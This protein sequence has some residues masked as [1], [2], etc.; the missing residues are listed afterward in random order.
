MKKNFTLTAMITLFSLSNLQAETTEN[1]VTEFSNR[2]L[3]DWQSKSFSG[4][5]D[6]QLVKEQ[7]RTVLKATSVDSASG[8]ALEKRI[9][10]FQTPYINWSWRIENKLT[11]LD[12][13]TKQGDDY[14]ARIYLIIDGGWTVWK[15]QALN[16]VWSSNQTQQTQ[17][18]NAYVD[19][20][21]MLAVRG[22]NATP[23][24]WYTEKRNVYQDLI[25]NFGDKGSAEKN[26][27]AYRYIDVTAIMT[28]TDNSHQTV[29]AYY[30]DITFTA[31]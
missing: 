31:N 4:N 11:G 28:D 10:L 27:K 23:K 18:N 1:N 13:Q 25:T 7:T 8:L 2:D 5:T 12:E 14:A 24:H 9:D 29:T 17:W 26:E 6:Y 30:G 16:Y 20:A 3:S 21:K 22:K 19:N 15:T